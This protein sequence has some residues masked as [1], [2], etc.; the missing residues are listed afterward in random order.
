[1]HLAPRANVF[2]MSWLL[3]FARLYFSTYILE[4][5]FFIYIIAN[6]YQPTKQTNKCLVE[7]HLPSIPVAVGSNKSK[8]NNNNK[9]SI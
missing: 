6:K 7:L 4:E 9:K 1:M 3:V 8:I 5:L 2:S